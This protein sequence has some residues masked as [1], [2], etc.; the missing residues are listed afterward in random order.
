MTMTIAELIDELGTM[1]DVNAKIAV[2]G[3]D[4]SFRQPYVVEDEDDDGNTIWVIE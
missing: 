3:P 2:R 1:D 4:H